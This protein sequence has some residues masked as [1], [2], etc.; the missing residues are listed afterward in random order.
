MQTKG[1]VHSL[2]L[3][4]YQKL[5]NWCRTRITSGAIKNQDKLPSENILQRKF[6]YSRQ[7]VRMALGQLE[8]DGLIV[9]VRGSGTYV[10]YEDRNGDNDGEPEGFRR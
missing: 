9:R 7:T 3:F 2:E 8:A 1:C 10:S 5:Y 4:K 6:G